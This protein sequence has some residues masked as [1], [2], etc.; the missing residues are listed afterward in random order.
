MGHAQPVAAL[1]AEVWQCALSEAR[2]ARGLGRDG[3]VPQQWP[4]GLRNVGE[5]VL[6]FDPAPGGLDR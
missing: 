2:F 1:V 6:F 4:G 5:V 3:R